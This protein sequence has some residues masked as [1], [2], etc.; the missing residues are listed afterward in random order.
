MSWPASRSRSSSPTHCAKPAPPHKPGYFSDPGSWPVGEGLQRSLID[1][2]GRE[3]P[4]EISLSSLP[5]A[6][7]TEVSMAI[8]DISER[9]AAQAE[10]ER[11]RAEAERER[12]GRRLQH[13]RNGQRTAPGTTT[14]PT[15]APGQAAQRSPVVASSSTQAAHHPEQP[16]RQE[17]PHDLAAG[18]AQP[19]PAA[20]LASAPTAAGHALT[21]PCMIT[22]LPA[23][24][25]SFSMS[26]GGPGSPAKRL[27]SAPHLS[28]RHP[29]NNRTLTR[30]DAKHVIHARF[31]PRENC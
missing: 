10:Q 8:R 20:K 16:S 19:P 31:A 24:A 2:D 15:A 21:T 28:H 9:L 3:F 6:S 23:G 12:F 29:G 13:T 18:L 1:K 22:C 14:G 5:T 4:I 25:I 17:T 26:T 27:S 11:L 7:G 30:Q